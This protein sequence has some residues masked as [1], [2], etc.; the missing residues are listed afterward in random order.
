MRK[1]R[2][3]KIAKMGNMT[4]SIDLVKK[5]GAKKGKTNNLFDGMS[6]DLTKKK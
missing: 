6:F 1:T 4:N 5:L 2:M 3:G